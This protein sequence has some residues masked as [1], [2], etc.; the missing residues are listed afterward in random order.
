MRHPRPI[1]DLEATS[2]TEL[3]PLS[4]RSSDDNDL[5]HELDELERIEA[6]RLEMSFNIDEDIYG[7][8]IFT[9]LYDGV[10]LMSDEREDLLSD[11]INRERLCLVLCVLVGNYILQIVM[12]S[13]VFTYMTQPAIH[14]VQAVYQK[15]HRRCFTAAGKF[16]DAAWQSFEEKSYLCDLP[17]TN[18]PFTY[19]VLSLW[20]MTILAEA[21]QVRVLHRN[22]HNVS[23]V[24]TLG[25]MFRHRTVER[26]EDEWKDKIAIIGFTTEVR[27]L[28]YVL[29][30]IPKLFVAFSLLIIGLPWLFAAPSY[31]SLILNSLSL[32]FIVNIDELLYA[33]IL[34]RPMKT[35]MENMK[36]IRTA[37]KRATIEMW[38]HQ[39]H[40]GIRRSFSYFIGTLLITA[41][42]LFAC[43]DIPFFGVLP[44]YQWDINVHCQ[45]Y[46]QK[47][48][49]RLCETGKHCFPYGSE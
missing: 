40:T 13:W 36:I 44:E 32:S 48:F 20:V 22:L 35:Q 26:T 9:I 8:T 17:L 14:H 4:S 10:D 27:M 5:D 7:A 47:H 37:K 39:Q 34:P 3:Q 42:Y 18:V 6:E 28:I 25:D 23:T 45:E 31:E 46:N 11:W 33:S 41:L 12:S 43:Q 19:A 30:V 16:D 49:N 2:A 21:K 24:D 38:Q 15:F 1:R 29:V